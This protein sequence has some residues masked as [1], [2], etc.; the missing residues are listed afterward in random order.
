[1]KSDTPRSFSSQMVIGAIVIALGIGFLLDNLNILN[2]GDAVS[3]W[4]VLFIVVGSMKLADS[5]GGKSNWGGAILI[6]I[7]CLLILRNLGYLHVNLRALWPLVLIFVGGAVVY[8]SVQRRKGVSLVKAA[9]GSDS[10]VDVTAILG[11]FDRRITTQNFLGGE[12]TAVMG[13]CELDLRGSSIQGEAVINVFAAMGGISMKVPPDWTVV[14][15]GTPIMGGFDEKTVN[16]PDA[17]KRLIIKGYAIM[18]GVEVT[19]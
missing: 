13:G 18:G 11:G 19:N 15:H 9:D 6:G 16:P 3:F 4:P 10:I 1:M 14:L 2:F 12:I 7:G 8:K 5:D 17:S